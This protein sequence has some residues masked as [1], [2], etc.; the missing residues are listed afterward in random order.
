MKVGD[1]V[2]FPRRKG[3]GRRKRKLDPLK[4][5]RRI[6]MAKGV[7]EDTGSVFTIIRTD[8]GHVYWVPHALVTK[9][10]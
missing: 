3:K 9:D 8:D 4:D 10:D 2:V 5:N 7:V 6:I 1:R